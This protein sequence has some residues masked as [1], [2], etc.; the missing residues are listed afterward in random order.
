MRFILCCSI[1]VLVASILLLSSCGQNSSTSDDASLL[2]QAREQIDDG[3]FDGALVFLAQVHTV[4]DDVIVLRA[5]A[6]AG[7]AGFRLL[8]LFDSFSSRPSQAEPVG[9][10]FI[11][12]QIF[13]GK[14]IAS[15]RYAVADIESYQ[16]LPD[17]S[18][19][20]NLRFAL[21][22]IYKAAQI[23]LNDANTATQGNGLSPSWQPCL[24]PQLPLL[25][26][27]EIIV[28]LNK[29]VRAINQIRQSF[30]SENLSVVYNTITKMQLA[31]GI[32]PNE[33]DDDQLSAAD[34]A[35][36]RTYLNQ[37]ITKR[38]AACQ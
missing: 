33:V 5:T 20:L 30:T 29:A 18:A 31:V 4:T 7:N 32:N 16:S 22:E 3:N 23:L 17:R 25:D 15:S 36:L 12:T 35:K 8:A 26:I 21:V 6:H 13:D 2:R 10:L 27:R 28:S 24:E 14:A 9:I 11:L 1:V 34:A 19:E 38:T 37:Q